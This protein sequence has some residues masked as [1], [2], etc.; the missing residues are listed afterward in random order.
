ME[1][2]QIT[3]RLPAELKKELQQEA[4]GFRSNYGYFRGNLGEYPM[5]NGDPISKLGITY[6]TDQSGTLSIL[7]TENNLI[8]AAKCVHN[9]N[10][11]F[12]G[13]STLNPDT[14]ITLNIVLQ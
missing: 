1:R 12:S 5:R 9:I 8:P 10:L 3:I 4:E 14:V 6:V 2:E 7:G 11:S 13:T